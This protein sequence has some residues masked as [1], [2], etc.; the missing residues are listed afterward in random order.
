MKQLLFSWVLSTLFAALAW[1]A[2]PSFTGCKVNFLGDRSAQIL[3][4]LSSAGSA[5][6]FRVLFDYDKSLDRGTGISS[7]DTANSLTR[8]ARIASLAPN[9]DVYFSPM[10]TDSSGSTWSSPFKCPVTCNSCSPSHHPF[11]LDAGPG[12][13]RISCTAGEPMRFHTLPLDTCEGGPPCYPASPTHQGLVTPPA[14]TGSSRTVAAGCTNL[15]ALINQAAAQAAAGGKVEEVLLPSTEVVC[16]PGNESLRRYT[17]PNACP[18]KVLIRSAADPKLLPPPGTAMD[19]GYLPHTGKLGWNNNLAD[20]ALSL[21]QFAGNSGCYYF[22]NLSVQ[23]PS[24]AVS[25]SAETP[26]LAAALGK[27]DDGKSVTDVTLDRVL[28]HRPFPWRSASGVVL[29]C[30]RC[31]YVNSWDYS[32]RWRIPGS[33]MENEPYYSMYFHGSRDFQ[34]VNN[35][36][37]GQPFLMIDN[38][39]QGAQNITIARNTLWNP[40]ST[41]LDSDNP[42]SDGLHYRHTFCIELKSCKNCRISANYFKGCRADF[43]QNGPAV[44]LAGSGDVSQSP[45]TDVQIADVEFAY[46]TIDRSGGGLMVTANDGGASRRRLPTERIWGHDNLILRIDKKYG[47]GCCAGGTASYAWE[48]VVDFI[49]ERNT[50]HVEAA[51]KPYATQCAS[52]GQ[53]HR[54]RNN[55]Y[56]ASQG[57]SGETGFGQL[58]G[59]SELPAPSSA[60]GSSAFQDCYVSGT[61]ADSLS[62]FGNNVIIP[63]VKA[64]MSGLFSA[65]AASRST[66]DTWCAQEAVSDPRWQGFSGLRFVGSSASPC[67]ESFEERLN[68][69]F[70]PGTWRP[71]SAYAANGANI[72]TLEEEQG[73]TE[74]I[75]VARQGPSSV[76]IS[77]M[78][79]TPKACW[80][81]VTPTTF[82]DVARMS[83]WRQALG[84][85]E[86]QSVVFSGLAPGTRYTYRVSCGQPSDF[87]IFTTE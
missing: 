71:K 56:V 23:P 18:G 80:A 51:P 73:W 10:T 14:V 16:R 25:V 49:W 39:W 31:A 44:A 61:N 52:R 8:N 21:L 87:G 41:V 45:Q 29:R 19:P 38:S 85:T 46:N 13:S 77:W 66:A 17:L 48:P 83:D 1:A 69:A 54:D 76:T 57:E 4:Y 20:T 2:P 7:G 12:H 5:Y 35:T 11:F 58:L 64:S 70:E 50:Y 3:C 43:N 34:I 40:D 28:I 15:Q 27:T 30:D 74:N 32:Q 65:K 60:N 82:S 24:L 9:T 36:F 67:N 81:Q 86:S 33:S 42:Q 26:A 63:G 47:L 59:G 68:A 78:A 62:F 22:S 6:K 84:G 53:G 75:T 37:Y 72:D 79:P 55:I